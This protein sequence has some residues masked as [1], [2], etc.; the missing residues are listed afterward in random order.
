MINSLFFACLGY[1]AAIAPMG[2]K[3]LYGHWKLEFENNVEE[4][5]FRADHTFESDILDQGIV[6]WKFA[7]TWNFAGDHLSYIYT[8]S[9]FAK[10]PP[11]TA[12][13]DTIV[14]LNTDDFLLRNAGQQYHR[15]RRVK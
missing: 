1:A 5:E 10:V 9:S 6:A 12:D 14:E 13:A 2:E 3:I 4:I 7:G 15:F 11:G 8:K